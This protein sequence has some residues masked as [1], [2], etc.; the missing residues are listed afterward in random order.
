MFKAL[1]LSMNLLIFWK[2]FVWA[3]NFFVLPIYCIKIKKK[4]IKL[5][6][7]KLY[8]NVQVNTTKNID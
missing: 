5:R 8:I 1:L 2:I 7:L 6:C 4:V 3:S